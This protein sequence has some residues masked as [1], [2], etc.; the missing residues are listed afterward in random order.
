MITIITIL[1]GL[2]FGFAFSVGNLASQYCRDH[3]YVSNPRM[4]VSCVSMKQ[5]DDA[6]AKRESNRTKF[7]RGR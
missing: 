7:G 1:H 5:L 4:D 2:A 6:N 3:Q